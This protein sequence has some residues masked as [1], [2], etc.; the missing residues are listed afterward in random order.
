MIKLGVWISLLIR[1]SIL[2]F[3]KWCG[4]FQPFNHTFPPLYSH[5]KPNPGCTIDIWYAFCELCM[6]FSHF[7][8]SL[9]QMHINMS[10]IYELSCVGSKVLQKY[11]PTIGYS[12]EAKSRL[13]NCQ[14][15]YI[16]G[17]LFRY[18][19][20][21]P[22]TAHMQIHISH[23]FEFCGL[24]VIIKLQFTTIGFIY[25]PKSRRYN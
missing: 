4:P 22:L 12:Y 20:F 18:S 13:Y 14:L 11:F 16:L 19:P 10:H 1:Y 9:K 6:I 3:F 25:E 15:I 7:N 2:I 17:I 21:Q 24:K 8:P 23:I 5:M